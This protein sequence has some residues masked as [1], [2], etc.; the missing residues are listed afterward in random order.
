MNKRNVLFILP[1]LPYPLESGGHQAIFNGIKA[2]C[3]DYNVFITYRKDINF[4]YQDDIDGL[5]K[6]LDSR[7]VVVPYLE[8]Q[9]PEPKFVKDD[10]ITKIQESLHNKYYQLG[11]RFPWLLT[12]GHYETIKVPRLE[13]RYWLDELKPKDD[14]YSKFISGLIDKYSIDVVQVEMLENISLV[15]SLPEKVKKIFVHHEI[16]FVRLALR[17]DIL[18]PESTECMSI[19]KMYKFMEVHLLNL[20]DTVVSLSS[21][22]TEKLKKAGVKTNVFTSFAMITPHKSDLISQDNCK[23]LVFVGPEAHNPNYQG[24]KWFLDNCWNKLLEHDA[25]YKLKIIGKWTEET[26]QQWLSKFSHITFSGFV[27]DLDDAIKGS[28][29]I[30]PITIGSGIRMKILEA[31]SI[32]VPVVSTTVGAEGIP[33]TN[34]ESGML[35]DDPIDFIDSIIRLKDARLYL[36]LIKGGNEIIKNMFSF[37]VLKENRIGIIDSVVNN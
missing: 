33:I 21:I 13:Y 9:R 6:V 36:Q 24:V 7:L 25:E 2:V 34:C 3:K 15:L 1:F 35:A 28:I 19:L 8:E 29:M 31:F 14:T 5:S 22:D 23:T 4:P 26:S 27:D 16:G 37:E 17:K 32:G 11:Q 12:T 10:S 20:Y 30:V 18:Y